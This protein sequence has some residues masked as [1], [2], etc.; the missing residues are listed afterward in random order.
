ML[1]CHRSSLEGRAGVAKELTSN[2]Y[3][4]TMVV[5]DLG[6]LQTHGRATTCRLPSLDARYKVLL[7]PVGRH[8]MEGIADRS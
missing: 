3:T 1:L 8:Q 4:I 7:P 2:G 5:D 6:E